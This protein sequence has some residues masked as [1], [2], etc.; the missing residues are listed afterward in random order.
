MK[1][2]IKQFTIRTRLSYF[3]IMKQRILKKIE[4]LKFKNIHLH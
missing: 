2:Y 4:I 3:Y 1:L